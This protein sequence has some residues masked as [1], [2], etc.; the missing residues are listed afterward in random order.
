MTMTVARRDG[1]TLEYVSVAEQAK[2]IRKALAKAFPK[3]K[4]YVRSHSYAGGASIDV[5]YDGTASLEQN[6]S[7]RYVRTYKPGAPTLEDVTAVTDAYAGGSFDGTIDLAYSIDRFVDED[8]AIV[9]A[10]TLG[11]EGSMGR[12]PAFSR[13]P[14]K[15]ARRVA[16]AGKYVFVE[17]EEPWDVRSKKEA[18]R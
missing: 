7:G 13:R 17:A 4:F 5:R 3:T 6:A 2:M 11:T 10:E 16:F 9:G 15:P 18:S 14:M 12:F 8:G 1:S